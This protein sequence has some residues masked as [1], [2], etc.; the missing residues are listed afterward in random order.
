MPTLAIYQ[1]LW[2]SYACTKLLIGGDFAY[3][4]IVAGHID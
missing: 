1:S 3:L 4:G 2:A